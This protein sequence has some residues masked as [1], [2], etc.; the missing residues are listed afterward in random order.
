MET[1]SRVRRADR[2]AGGLEGLLIGDALGV[3]Y[4]FTSAAMIPAR[5]RI[6]FEPPVDFERSHESVLPGTWSDDG[7]Q[8]LCVLE[9]LLDEGCLQLDGFAARLVRWLDDGYFAV[10]SSVFDCGIQTAR[11]IRALRGGAAPERAGPSAEADNGN[12]ALMR[13]L[14]LALWHRG[15]DALLV[16]DAQ[17]QS[18]PTH[19][20][21]RSQLCCGLYC[22]WVRRYLEEHPAPWD[23]AV[24][25]LRAL[26]AD[27]ASLLAE[28]EGP[29]GVDRA[30][31]PN[32]QGYVV[33]CL[34]SARHC[35][36]E[37]D[38][39]GVVKAR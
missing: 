26:C 39:E 13:V 7:A 21:P 18:L 11:A 22:L 36:Q 1:Q 35:L 16:R 10:D 4:E 38:Y 14:P 27:E 23:N 2:L 29:I 17:R 34:Q 6:E 25:T 32:G 9:T 31:E 33:D 20:H 8:A 28:L 12:G 3:P 24:A 5:A 30:P 15:S 37:P 19:G